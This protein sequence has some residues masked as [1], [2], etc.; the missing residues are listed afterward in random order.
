MRAIEAPSVKVPEVPVTVMVA[1]PVVAVLLAL[2][3]KVLAVVAGLGLNDAVTPLGKPAADKLTLLPKPFCGVTVIVLVTLA[4]CVRVRLLGEAERLKFPAVFT[5]RTIVVAFVRL[6]DVP[7]IVTLTVPV[8]VVLLAASVK[9]LAVLV[10]FGL[11]DAVTPLGKPVAD[12]L[13]L[14]P[15]PFCGVTVIVLVPALP[16][17]MVRLSGEVERMKFGAVV[18]QLLTRLAALILPIPVA[19]SQPAEVPYAKLYELLAVEST[20]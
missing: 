13:T 19:K 11:K 15:K 20:P 9:V 10:G 16:W 8:V 1:V 2:S 17:E 4:P 14:L 7:I 3:V 18:G 6:P 12:K 5:E